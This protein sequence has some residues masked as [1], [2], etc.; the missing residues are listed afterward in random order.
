[1]TEDRQTNRFPKDDVDFLVQE[2]DRML[3]NIHK[4]YREIDN[5]RKEEQT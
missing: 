3:N 1:M 2:N 5:L 4:L